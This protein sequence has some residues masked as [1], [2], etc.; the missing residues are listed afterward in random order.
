MDGAAFPPGDGPGRAQIGRGPALDVRWTFPAAS[1]AS[2]LFIL[3][4]RAANAVEVSGIRGTSSWRLLPGRRNFDVEAA[5]ATLT[6]PESVALLGDPWV[7]E[8]GWAVTREPRGLTAAKSPVVRGESATLGVSFTIDTLAVAEPLW[9]FQRGRARE[10]APAFVAAGLF[11]VVVAFGVVGMV[12]LKHPSWRAPAET[13]GPSITPA[14]RLAIRRGRCRGDRPEV[15][16]A[17]DGLVARGI[18]NVRTGAALSPDARLQL[19]GDTQDIALLAHERVLTD[20][21]W[22]RRAEPVLI[23][24]LM[25][26]RLARRMRRGLA[27]DLVTA[28]LFDRERLAAVRDLQVAGLVTVGLGVAAWL[29]VRLL[30]G[31]FGRWPLFVP[32]GLVVG[33]VLLVAGARVVSVLS[34]AGAQ[35]AA[36]RGDAT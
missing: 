23:G 6:L 12:R 7:E 30:L 21:L 34:A 36:H 35:A 26:K 5:S 15:V 22:Y 27:A 3:R 16:A 8:A 28:G 20:E 29:G 9:Q 4:Y 19:A 1:D 18:V 31:A 10:F 32:A 24:G 11:L 2:H 17:L 25:T 13:R 33:G 14:M